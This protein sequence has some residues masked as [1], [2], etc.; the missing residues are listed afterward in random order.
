MAKSGQYASDRWVTPGVVIAGI[1][2]GGLV[3]AV[4]AG[5]V[6]YLAALG[7][8]PDPM[9][10][11]T[12]QLVGAVG[13]LGTL[14]LQLV[15]RTTATKTERNAGIT[16]G[17]VVDL[18]DALPA[19]AAAPSPSPRYVDDLD[20]HEPATQQRTE[21]PPLPDYSRHHRRSPA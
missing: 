9:L 19:A 18:V 17:V 7:I 16:A 1:V 2:V 3:V 20:D 5:G 11:L 12:A 8:D 10:K 6:T 13:S 14:V 4:V 15:G 21:I